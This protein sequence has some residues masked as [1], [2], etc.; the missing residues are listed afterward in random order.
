[1]AASNSGVPSKELGWGDSKL[2][3]NAYTWLIV[4]SLHTLIRFDHLAS[5]APL[6]IG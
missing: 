3:A 5:L 2:L 4:G 1:V 6:C